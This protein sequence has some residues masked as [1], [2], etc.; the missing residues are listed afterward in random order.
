MLSGA[1]MKLNAIG[2]ISQN[3]QNSLNFYK[4]LGVNFKQFETTDHYECVLKN[5]LKLMLDSEELMKK[6]QPNWEPG[7]KSKISLCFQVD[8][9]SEVDL[10]FETI[11]ARKY[12]AIKKPWDAFWGQRYATVLDPDNNQIDLFSDL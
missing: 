3:I 12:K 6:I 10:I 9:P 11:I 7:N 5:D 2:I 4:L 8:K 1:T